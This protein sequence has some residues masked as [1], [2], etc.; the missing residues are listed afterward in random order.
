MWLIRCE[1]PIGELVVEAIVVVSHVLE[2]HQRV[3][4]RQSFLSG[5]VK[6]IG[7]VRVAEDGGQAGSQVRVLRLLCMVLKRLNSA[8]EGIVLV[9]KL[10]DMA[11]KL[12]YAAR[13]GIVRDRQQNTNEE[14]A[15]NRCDP[16]P[17]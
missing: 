6:A 5:R 3:V 2:A 12:L 4:V 1:S 14:Q 8:L 16:L 17:L 11:L 15:A 9:L 13:V 10:L 7:C